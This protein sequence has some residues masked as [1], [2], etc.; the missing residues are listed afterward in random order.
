MQASCLTRRKEVRHVQDNSMLCAS[1]ALP[2]VAFRRWKPRLGDAVDDPRLEGRRGRQIPQGHARSCEGQAPGALDWR[3][4][5]GC[6][7]LGPACARS[8]RAKSVVA[9]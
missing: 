6:Q 9:K 7:G 8:T 1:L 3:G 5:Q 2:A 4:G